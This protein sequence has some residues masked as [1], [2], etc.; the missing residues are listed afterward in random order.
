VVPDADPISNLN[1]NAAIRGLLLGTS[2][3]LGDDYRGIWGLFGIFDYRSP[4]SSGS[5][6]RRSGSAPSASGGSHARSRCRAPSSAASDSVPPAPSATRRSVTTTTG[7]FQRYCSACARSSTNGSWSTR[8]AARTSWPARARAAGS[9]PATSA[10]RSSI[11]SISGAPCASGGLT[12]SACSIWSRPA[13]RACR[14]WGSSPAGRDRQPHLQL[15]GPHAVRRRRVAPRGDR[16]PLSRRAGHATPSSA[17][18]EAAR[19]VAAAVA[20]VD[21]SI[22][23]RRMSGRNRGTAA[24]I[25]A[26]SQKS[27]ANARSWACVTVSR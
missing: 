2:Y 10:A 16:Q 9:A 27:S 22:R 5:R 3:E 6:R 21:G 18:R 1:E 11:A 7:S 15:P 17:T 20:A 26:S 24:N 4:Q 19:S 12:G 8:R 25:T 13:T 23:T 14:A